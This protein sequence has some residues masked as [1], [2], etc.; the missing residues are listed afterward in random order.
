MKIFVTGS[1]G[2]IGSVLVEKLIE[3]GHELRT[4]DQKAAPKDC[5][6]AHTPGDV[7]D[8]ALVR[9][10]TQGV[11]IVL[12][13]AAD[14]TDTGQNQ[15]NT[16]TVNIQGTWNVLMAC[17]ET[18]VSRLVYFSSLQAL[19]HS[20][21]A[22]TE[23]YFP[24]D[25]RV[26]KQPATPYQI[27]KHAAEEMCRAFTLQNDLTVASL[28]PTFVFVP[29]KTR[30]QGWGRL[31]EEELVR[32]GRKDYWSFVHVEDVCQAAILSMTAPIKNFQGFLLTSDHTWIDVPTARLVEDHYSKFVWKDTTPAAYLV[33]D[34]YRSLIDC[35]AAKEALG[36]RPVHSTRQTIRQA[37]WVENDG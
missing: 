15:E 36:W 7:R 32:L 27:S 22:H 9:R 1:Q 33:E 16:F 35:S 20:N 30:L 14:L 37:L 25:D 26:P 21:A 18:G 31:P 19:G 4:L 23:I 3:A 29:G 17:A 24:I 8:L 10:L 13:L 34:T 12:H 28:R 6:W 11:D 2:G 5:T